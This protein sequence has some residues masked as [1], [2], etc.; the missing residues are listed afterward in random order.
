MRERRFLSRENE[1]KKKFESHPSFKYKMQV[2]GSKMLLRICRALI[3]TEVN[4]SRCCRGSVDG[5]RVI[6]MDRGFVEKLL[7]R[8]RA[9]KFSMMD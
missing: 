2:D 7:V 9:Q 8:Q 1:K 3:S 5:K 4:L 6:S